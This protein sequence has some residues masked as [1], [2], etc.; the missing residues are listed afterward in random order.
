MKMQLNA[1]HHLEPLLNCLFRRWKLHKAVSFEY[2]KDPVYDI[3]KIINVRAI[4]SNYITAETIWCMC[5]NSPIHYLEELIKFDNTDENASGTKK[6]APS[7][8]NPAG[9][10]GGGTS[11][12]KGGR[13]PR[14]EIKDRLERAFYILNTLLKI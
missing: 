4:K 1:L 5:E 11:G 9:S 10:Y 8:F 2:K 14:S 7:F 12:N 13:S 6:G 3:I